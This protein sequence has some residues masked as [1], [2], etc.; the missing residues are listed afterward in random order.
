MEEAV[1]IGSSSF[2][3]DGRLVRN[4]LQERVQLT[5]EDVH[6]LTRQVNSYEFWNR[7]GLRFVDQISTTS[8]ER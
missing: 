3:T 8:Y 6:L 4:V 1:G 5:L 2:L 7:A